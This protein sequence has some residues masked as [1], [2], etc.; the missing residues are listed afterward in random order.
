MDGHT[1]KLLK[2]LKKTVSFQMKSYA[3]RQSTQDMSGQ[4]ETQARKGFGIPVWSNLR[5]II[6]IK[7]FVNGEMAGYNSAQVGVETMIR[8]LVN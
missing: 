5:Y 8:R 4:T 2:P 1:M 3:N 6:R 7:T